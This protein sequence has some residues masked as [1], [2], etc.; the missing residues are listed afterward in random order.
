MR[1]PGLGE[2]DVEEEEGE[3]DGADDAPA[4]SPVDTQLRLQHEV[5][6]PYWEDGDVQTSQLVSSSVSQ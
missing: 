2:E 1:Y 3:E 5:E 6:V 4:E